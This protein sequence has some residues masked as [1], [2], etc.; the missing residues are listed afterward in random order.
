MAP[1][2]AGGRAARAVSAPHPGLAR[3]LR[4]WQRRTVFATVALALTSGEAN[5]Q[6]PDPALF[7]QLQRLERQGVDVRVW[8]APAR[9]PYVGRVSQLDE[10]SAR[11]GRGTA[12]L[13][14]IRSVE[15]GRKHGGGT[16]TGAVIGGVSGGVAALGFIRMLSD[17]EPTLGESLAAAAV[18]ALPGM[19]IGAVIGAAG[20]PARIEWIPV[21]PGDE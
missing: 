4:C 5:A 2:L 8:I 14:A 10:S 17:G 6:V 1:A 20:W 13:S 11:I 21:W 7:S 19:L 3:V 15:F 9:P 18:G 12:P 16:G